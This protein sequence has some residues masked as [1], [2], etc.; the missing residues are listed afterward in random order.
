VVD[1]YARNKELINEREQMLLNKK[2][3]A[4]VGLGGLGGHIAEQL[5]R[6]GLGHLILIDDD[7]VE[8]TDLNRQLFATHKTLGISKTDAAYLRLC[9]VNPETSCTMYAV[10]LTN[11]NG[12]ELLN[13]ADI[14]LDAVDNIR[15]RLVLE[16]VCAQL[17]LPLIHGSIGGWW[18]QVSVVFPGDGTDRKSVV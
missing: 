6:L 15:T 13:N 9:E 7:I 11:E 18:G 17:N 2:T 12:I 3:A 5:A 10:R 14:V 4:V 16:S 8:P 1:K